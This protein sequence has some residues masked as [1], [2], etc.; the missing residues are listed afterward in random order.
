MT[1]SFYAKNKDKL[2]PNSV[3]SQNNQSKLSS[4]LPPSR[5]S[6]PTNLYKLPPKSLN[7]IKSRLKAHTSSKSFNSSRSKSKRRSKGSSPVTNSTTKNSINELINNKHNLNSVNNTNQSLTSFTYVNSPNAMNTSHKPNI[8][9]AKPSHT[10]FVSKL[11][12]RHNQNGHAFNSN[13]ES[14]KSSE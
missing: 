4:Y 1:N 6:K 11:E 8:N 10:G 2:D 12:S 13:L 7:S 3:S 14:E 5:K 9:M